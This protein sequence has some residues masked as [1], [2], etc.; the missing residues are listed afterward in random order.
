[1]REISLVDAAGFGAL[2]TGGYYGLV[3]LFPW[4]AAFSPGTNMAVLVPV[5]F[6]ITTMA[7]FCYAALGSAMPRAGGDYLYESRS[8]HR[9]VGFCIP[10]TCQVVFWLAFGTMGSY[11]INGFG[12][13]PMT[14]ALGLES[15]SSW[16]STGAG[17]FT[18]TA[19]A[20]ACMWALVVAGTRVYRK[21]QKYVL[22]PGLVIGAITIIAVLL[23]NWNADFGAAFD[24][25]YDG[26]I[27]VQGVQEAAAELGYTTPSFNWLNTLIW[28][29]VLVGGNFGYTMYAAQGLLGEVKEASNLKRLFYAFF[30][31]GALVAFGM[32]LLPWQLLQHIT[33]SEFLNQ[34]AWA[35]ANGAVD[36][37]AQP[38]IGEFAQM[39]SPNDVVTVLISLGF[40]AGG[41]GIAVTVYMN[42][43][44]VMMAMSLDGMLPGFLSK[45][46]HRTYT[47]A[48][49][50]TVWSVISLLVATWFY[51]D[52]RWQTAI[53]LG[54]AVT[55]LLVV[56]VTSAGAGIFP[57][58]ARE[59]YKSAPVARL[60]IGSVPLVTVIGLIAGACLFVTVY[61][62]LTQP[63]IG[64]TGRDV[65]IALL[66]AFISGPIIYVLWGF[67]RRSKGIDVALTTREV[68]PE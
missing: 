1:M 26:S 23:A 13:I 52:V 19:V 24:A 37:G 9:W 35:Y 67:Y 61:W 45:V 21:V 5:T 49:A 63:A 64:L 51:Y 58:T 29:G 55:S 68:P 34:Y 31:P 7:Y 66:V 62:A 16:L 47:P 43:A 12:L 53:I 32:I 28:V 48:L 17:G 38:N 56:A 39:L 4:A 42:V 25:Y 2:A 3:Y 59:I 8:I 57:F 44:R 6:V 46:W 36:P 15:V 18:V 50:M 60:R 14:Q 30:I 11:I 54:G 27:T 40:L 41:F 33:G 22:V 65:R 20:I 10:W